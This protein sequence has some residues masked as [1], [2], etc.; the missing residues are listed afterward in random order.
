MN[1]KD[2]HGVSLQG[3]SRGLGLG[4][5]ERGLEKRDVVCVHGT[6]PCRVP[7]PP[8]EPGNWGKKSDLLTRW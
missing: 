3:L 2:Q 5:R 8:E 7:S 4:Y 6:E 1:F